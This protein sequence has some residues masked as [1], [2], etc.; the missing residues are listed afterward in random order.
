MPEESVD[1][2]RSTTAALSES[3]AAAASSASRV[4]AGSRATRSWNTR[5]SR[6]RHRQRLGQRLVARE[7]RGAQRR[8]QLDERQR[9][10]VGLLEQPLADLRRGRRGGVRE[11]LG[12][13]R[14]VE[15]VDR[16]RGHVGRLEHAHVALARAEQ[17]HDALGIE[18]ARDELQRVG[19]PGI[20]PVGVVDEAQDRL[21]LGELGQQ[22]QRTGVDEE[23][24]LPAAVREPERGPQRGGLRCGQPVEVA[25]RRAQKL[26]QRGER[27]LG[28][29][30]DPARGEHVHVARAGARV[31]EQDRLADTGLAAQRQRSAPRVAGRVEQCADEGA[32]S[33]PPK[34]HRPTLPMGVATI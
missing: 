13:G 29:R 28:L 21:L 25:Q 12:G 2:A 34:Q 19:G 32:L 8:R 33:V 3:S 11:Q 6:A 1:T 7:L 4:V 10:A 30:L 31:L 17:E 27:Q 22:R 23:A 5:S 14:V 24:L 16:V 26:L 18:P 9:V 20:E 15:A